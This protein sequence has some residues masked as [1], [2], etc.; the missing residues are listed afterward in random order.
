MVIVTIVP[1]KDNV[2]MLN[3]SFCACSSYISMPEISVKLP[4]FIL[5]KFNSVLNPRP[6]GASNAFVEF[7][8]MIAHS[9]ELFGKTVAL[10]F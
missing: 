3:R 5:R 1:G 7:P 4:L 9:K 6:P 10:F 2:S 8:G